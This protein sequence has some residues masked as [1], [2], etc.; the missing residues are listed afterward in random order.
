MSSH[1]PLPLSVPDAIRQRRTTKKFKPDPI[2]EAT[3]KEL[4]ALTLAA[5]SSYNLQPWRIVLV[6][7]PVQKEALGKASWNQA[8][9]TTAPVTFVFAV[10]IRGWKKTL[11]TTV[12]TAFEL[13]AWSEK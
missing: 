5:P 10:N 3:L 4:I 2:P 13:G 12:K 1:L 6:D 7:D 11:D 9:V 8:Q